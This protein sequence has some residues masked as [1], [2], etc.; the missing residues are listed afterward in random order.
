MDPRVHTPREGLLQQFTLSKHCYDDLQKSRKIMDEV[1]A[2]REKLRT[3]P[4]SALE[5][6]LNAIAGPPGGGGRFG[7]GG[8]R[9]APQGPD[10]IASVS[11]ALNQLM[12][13][14][15]NADVAPTTQMAAAVADRRAALAKL[16]ARWKTMQP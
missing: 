6:K 14:I 10:T 4:D 15:E 12:H 11:A 16:M 3:N 5:E 7:G 1:R 8:G 13:A 9:G 2:M